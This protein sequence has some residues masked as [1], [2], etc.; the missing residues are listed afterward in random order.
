MI[1]CPM[2]AHK[3]HARGQLLGVNNVTTTELAQGPNNL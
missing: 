3:G 2:R 1:V